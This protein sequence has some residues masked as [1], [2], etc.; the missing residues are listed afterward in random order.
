M[1][2]RI[3]VDIG[4]T[5]ADFCAFDEAKGTLHTLKVLT[6][7]LEPGNEIGTG[8]DLLAA[9]HG[10]SPTAITAF[11]HGTTVGINT[12][13]QRR[14]AKLGLI[15]TRGFEDVLELARLQMPDMY[16]LFCSRPEQLIPRDRI[17]G[18]GERVLSDGSIETA[19][20]EAELAPVL[21]KAKA[22]G[23][24]GLVISFLNAYRNQAHEQAVKRLCQKLSPEM[25][26]FAG[27]EVWPV[28]REYERTCTAILN[29]YV[30]PRVAGYLGALEQRL[31][32][33]GIPARAMI[34]KSNGGIM[35]ASL[36]K[37]DCVGML[38]SGT[39]SGVM[40]AAY[41]ATQADVGN[42]LTLDIGGTSADVA[43]IIDGAPQFASGE[44]VGDFPLNIPSVSVT[45]I[46][47]GGGSI[48][49]V[50]SYGVL[51]IGPES[52]GSTPG[53]AS[54]GRGGTQATITDAMVVCGFL[55]HAPL[56]YSAI[57]LDKAAAETALAP[58]AKAMGRSLPETADA[59]I[60]VSVSNMFVE[61][62]KLIARFGVDPRD[63]TLLPF[64]GAGPMLG[65]LL[66]TEIGVGR[67]MVPRRPG[68]VS[69]LG[70]LI[71]D[72][73]SDFAASVFAPV[74]TE[75]TTRLRQAVAELRMTAE[76]WLREQQG[77]EGEANVTLSADMRYTGQSFEVEVPLEAAWI[78]TGNV[79]AIADAFHRRHTAI[80]DFAD[81]K[82][83]TYI[84]NMRLVI[85]GP[86]AK[87]HFAELPRAQGP[88]TPERQIDAW[89]DGETH[90]LPLYMRERL[91]F[92]QTL[93]G[94]AVIA[95]EDTTTIVPPGW[96]GEVDRFGNLHLTRQA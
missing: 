12:I 9:R 45:S 84:V 63:F 20:D 73:K 79:A 88:A 64:G 44:I 74:T 52:A 94:P 33:R 49:K 6:T 35:S 27:A 28:V 95:Q 96:H 51:K 60:R 86:T 66:A 17:W 61:V 71:A 32:E 43:L 30:H 69:A 39:A 90:T 89:F 56:A 91:G 65:C 50:D 85:A 21:A 70:G 22:K 72:V 31:A 14:G 55:G 68:V 25:F 10:V 58:L 19:F 5:F 42:V 54:Y 36:G 83:E 80:Y 24:D 4:G 81:E 7:P 67:V 53:P 23:C 18:I 78:E 87:P 92:G 1:A 77:Y 57:G 75:T 8:L 62:N 46:G 2:W 40:G 16:S 38:L 47:D 13:I 34:T 82:A 93:E 37:L 41:V 11:V 3:G 59:M 26:V 48:A 29:A 76:R 15:T